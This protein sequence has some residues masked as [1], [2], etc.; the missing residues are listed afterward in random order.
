MR[1]TYGRLT[2]RRRFVPAPGPRPTRR[3]STN[4]RVP[5]DGPRSPPAA[6]ASS[7]RGLGFSA[8]LPFALGPET[9]AFDGEFGKSAR[10][11]KAAEERHRREMEALGQ[12]SPRDV[13]ELVLPP[14]G[15]D[16]AHAASQPFLA[17]PGTPYAPIAAPGADVASAFPLHRTSP[18]N[19]QA[20]KDTK[21]A[22]KPARVGEDEDADDDEQRDAFRDEDWPE[23]AGDHHVATPASHPAPTGAAKSGGTDDHHTSAT[24][25]EPAVTA[26]RLVI[27]RP[28]KP[29]AAERLR[30]RQNVRD[31][32][33]PKEGRAQRRNSFDDADD[34]ARA[35]ARAALPDAPPKGRYGAEGFAARRAFNGLRLYR[36]VARLRVA[37]ANAPA[38]P[39]G[40]VGWSRGASKAAAHVAALAANLESVGEELVRDCD[41][42]ARWARY[43]H[44]QRYFRGLFQPAPA[45]VPRPGTAV[46]DGTTIADAGR[47]ESLSP[48]QV[49]NEG[50]P[51]HPDPAS[52]SSTA[53]G[54]STADVADVAVSTTDEHRKAADPGP[55]AE[56]QSPTRVRMLGYSFLATAHRLAGH[57]TSELSALHAAVETLTMR[58]IAHP[59]EGSAASRAARLAYRH[60]LASG[61][62]AGKSVSERHPL[63]GLATV[64]EP[65][66]V[67]LLADV[68]QQRATAH[69]DLGA[70]ALAAA[71][72]TMML[73]LPPAAGTPDGTLPP[74]LHFD[75]LLNGDAGP[76]GCLPPDAQAQALEERAAARDGLGDTD[77]AVADRARSRQLLADSGTAAKL[78]EAV[79]PMQLPPSPAS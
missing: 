38:G 61:T 6:A 71:D 25:V 42:V 69:N 40:R 36:D 27:P 16:G 74:A 65:S 43:S 8:S 32:C 11:A 54:S 55:L 66:D 67:P 68:L 21:A 62:E 3:F 53:T 35:V 14:A 18:A 60:R 78:G 75:A 73:S 59:D 39:N 5:S 2:M 51:P 31:L 19:A 57:P 44:V 1:A 58:E 4:D 22:A 64:M 79:A 24:A 33:M 10:D 56:L 13:A 28:A 15:A 23:D 34:D 47:A 63:V 45:P 76:H 46:S 70:F 52:P 50:A 37:L 30:H 20:T 7:T 49:K 77:G 29:T 41:L 26:S 9:D 48:A 72:A 12:L 17:H